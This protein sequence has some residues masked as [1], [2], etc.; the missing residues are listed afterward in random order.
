[1]LLKFFLTLVSPLVQL[2]LEKNLS[3]A[4]CSRFSFL[5]AAISAGLQSELLIFRCSHTLRIRPTG[6]TVPH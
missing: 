4:S 5:E 6:R 3:G 1:M 2:F